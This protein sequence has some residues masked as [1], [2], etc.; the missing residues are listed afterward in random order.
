MVDHGLSSE[1]I[2]YVCNQALLRKGGYNT[3]LKSIV[4]NQSTVTYFVKEDL[5]T[6]EQANI[7]ANM[8]YREGKH[9]LDFLSLNGVYE[10][11]FSKSSVKLDEYDNIY[12]DGFDKTTQRKCAVSEN[13]AS[14]LSLQNLCKSINPNFEPFTVESSPIR[15]YHPRIITVNKDGIND[16]IATQVFYGN[17]GRYFL[18]AFDVYL[19]LFGQSRLSDITDNY[20]LALLAKILVGKVR[21]YPI[22][23]EEKL[24]FSE[25]RQARLELQALYALDWSIINCE[26]MDNVIDAHSDDIAKAL[27]ALPDD[28]DY[29]QYQSYSG[30]INEL[31]Q[32]FSNINSPEKELDNPSD[33]MIDELVDEV[34]LIG[35]E[36]TPDQIRD[37]LDDKGYMKTV[38]SFVK[39]NSGNLLIGSATLTIIA[40]AVYLVYTGQNRDIRHDSDKVINF[41]KL[42]KRGTIDKFVQTL[43][44]TGDIIAKNKTINNFV[45]ETLMGILDSFKGI[46]NSLLNCPLPSSHIYDDKPIEPIPCA[47]YEFS[48]DTSSTLFKWLQYSN[49]NPYVEGS[50]HMSELLLPFVPNRTY[51]DSWPGVMALV[52][53]LRYTVSVAT[54]IV[55]FSAVS[56][57]RD[58]INYIKNKRAGGSNKKQF[59]ASTVVGLTTG[60]LM[61]YWMI[62]IEKL[63]NYDEFSHQLVGS[64][65][66]YLWLIRIWNIAIA[67]TYLS[68]KVLL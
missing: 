12:F 27:T 31:I 50:Q 39:K 59:F 15:I 23:I 48:P 35:G 17:N 2:T 30:K 58:I 63:P 36:M 43:S 42:V 37:V 38:V 65:F 16:F 49:I 14:T 61:H 19:R 22:G 11:Y 34:T 32:V 9:L 6:L 18:E 44:E 29:S 33:E 7:N 5:V 1:F 28:T 52:G 66:V 53:S 47:N 67:G 25:R 62:Q 54:G 21:K 26:Q 24:I 40:A 20:E 60:M 13:K 10:Y 56:F 8:L 64:S 51:S 4:A 46:R 55:G 45:N 57:A 68:K 3:L 41:I